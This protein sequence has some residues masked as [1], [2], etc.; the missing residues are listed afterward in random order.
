M[1]AT[2]ESFLL[3]RLLNLLGMN[4]SFFSFRMLMLMLRE[5]LCVVLLLFFYDSLLDN[6]LATVGTG[7]F[8]N[9]MRKAKRAVLVLQDIPARQSMVAP[10][11]S[12]MRS[13]VAHPY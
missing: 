13:S 2:K 9:A 12:R 1:Y 7:C 8:V 5:A 10:A 11:V 4:R 3:G 6:L